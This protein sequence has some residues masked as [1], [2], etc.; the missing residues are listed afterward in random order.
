MP[1]KYCTHDAWKKDRKKG[2]RFLARFLGGHP[3]KTEKISFVVAESN[4][5]IT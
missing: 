1:S 3:K 2:K 4:H 5:L